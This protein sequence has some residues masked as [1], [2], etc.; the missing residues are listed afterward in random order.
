MAKDTCSA[1]D[2]SPSFYDGKCGIAPVGTS[3]GSTSTTSSGTT[4]TSANTATT[5]VSSGLFGNN[6][7]IGAYSFPPNERIPQKVA[8][9][10]NFIMTKITKVL[11]RKAGVNQA[12]RAKYYQALDAYMSNRAQKSV[13]E[14]DRRI[15]EYLR[16]RLV[17]VSKG[18]LSALT[19][20]LSQGERGIVSSPSA[21][22]F[23]SLGIDFSHAALASYDF[24]Q[25]K[26][27]PKT[28]TNVL[29]GFVQTIASRAESAS[30]RAVLYK[31]AFAA[32]DDRMR[33]TT[34]IKERKIVQYVRNHVYIRQQENMMV[35]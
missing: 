14:K 1:G 32:L 9:E 19:P 26:R 29:D 28:V 35:R 22:D 3:T 4:S 6:P 33:T 8:S 24:A 15:L 10:L 18:L 7:I 11:D 13:S 2:Y 16:I 20:T 31:Q 30:N 21:V 17:T 25:D 23:S 5:S 27:F 34:D 12:K